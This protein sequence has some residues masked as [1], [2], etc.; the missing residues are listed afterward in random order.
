MISRHNQP[1]TDNKTGG[2]AVRTV[3]QKREDPL[4]RVWPL[5]AKLQIKRNSGVVGSGSPRRLVCPGL[6]REQ[7]NRNNRNTNAKKLPLHMM[8]SFRQRCLPC[9]MSRFND[10]AQLLPNLLP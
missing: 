4:N 9:S 1:V 5:L 7:K 10:L 2:E 6:R 3:I 8:V